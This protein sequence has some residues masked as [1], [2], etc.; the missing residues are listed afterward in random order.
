MIGTLIGAGLSAVGSIFGAAKAAKERKKVKAN[1]QKQLAE[2]QT[3]YDQHYNEDITQ[4]ADA[5]RALENARQ[6]IRERD[7]TADATAAVVGG[8]DA[9]SST[10]REQGTKALADAT[11]AIANQ[12]IAE[13]Q[14]VEKI[15]R[16]NRANLLGQLSNYDG[17]TAGN[18]ANAASMLGETAMNIGN[19]WDTHNDARR[20]EARQSDL[21]RLL[22]GDTQEVF[23]PTSN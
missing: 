20:E 2:N 15:Y 22:A 4:R 13:K 3:W 14:N 7:Q 11:A 17:Q 18:I 19:A 21:I 16:N 23:Q 10:I 9:H 12:G 5:V 1:T 8:T 6:T